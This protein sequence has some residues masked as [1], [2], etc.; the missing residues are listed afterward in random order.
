LL[1]HHLSRETQVPIKS[2]VNKVLI[3]G[4]ALEGWALLTTGVEG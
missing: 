4:A 1:E 2:F 3:E